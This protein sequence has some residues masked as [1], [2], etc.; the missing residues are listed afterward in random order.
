ML[1][2]IQL[3]AAVQQALDALEDAGVPRALVVLG[4]TNPHVA[5][6]D[7]HYDTHVGATLDHDNATLVEIVAADLAD[8]ARRAAVALI[9]RERCPSCKSPRLAY[10]QRR[11]EPRPGE[12]PGIYVETLDDCLDCDYRAERTRSC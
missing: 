9:R 2:P 5:G 7:T 12:R 8:E 6:Q 3:A 4:V 10:L 11:R 1:T